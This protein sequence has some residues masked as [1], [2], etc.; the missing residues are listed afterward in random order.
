VPEQ[1]AR[2]PAMSHRATLAAGSRH[3]LFSSTRPPACSCAS[4]RSPQST[5][6]GTVTSKCVRP[7]G[8]T[9]K[10]TRLSPGGS[11]YGRSVRSR[12][13]KLAFYQGARARRTTVCSVLEP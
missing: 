4:L 1:E 5:D 9:H 6:G 12:G 11:G 10:K 2:T 13:R 3:A 7:A 8:R